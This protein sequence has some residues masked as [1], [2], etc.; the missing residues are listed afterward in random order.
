[1]FTSRPFQSPHCAMALKHVNQKAARCYWCQI[2]VTPLVP[3]QNAAGGPKVVTLT[4]LRSSAHRNAA[5]GWC[6]SSLL[7]CL[8]HCI[9]VH[10]SYWI[11]GQILWQISHWDHKTWVNSTW[12]SI[13][14]CST[15]CNVVASKWHSSQLDTRLAKSCM[16][17]QFC[18]YGSLR[19]DC[20]LYSRIQE[21]VTSEVEG[22]VNYK[23]HSSKRGFSYLPPPSATSCWRIIWAASKKACFKCQRSKVER[24]VICNL[25]RWGCNHMSCLLQSSV[26]GLALLWRKKTGGKQKLNLA[27]NNFPLWIFCHINLRPLRVN[28][29]L[30]A[31]RTH[32]ADNFVL[33][34]TSLCLGTIY[35]QA[36]TISN[37]SVITM[38][39]S[40]RLLWHLWQF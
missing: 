20:A 4:P 29:D 10:D 30:G 39:I 28:A 13:S 23:H 26:K 11:H 34:A 8:T 25:Q 33:S 1:M 22:V 40:L 18:F 24:A 2:V 35:G 37:S 19:P 31:R 3:K 7:L 12:D 17:G 9:E 5:N 32:L 38:A 6:G 36:M 14:L 27:N 21:R 16:F 15:E